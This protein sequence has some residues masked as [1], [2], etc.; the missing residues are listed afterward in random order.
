VHGIDEVRAGAG[1]EEQV[2]VVGACDRE[3][4]A[5]PDRLHQFF[6]RLAGAQADNEFT[7]TQRLPVSGRLY[8]PGRG[9]F[10]D[11]AVSHFVA[12]GTA[13]EQHG[14]D[15]TGGLQG[16]RRPAGAALHR[17]RRPM[18]GSS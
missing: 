8:G 10:S 14:G 4:T 5:R 15:K 13:G 3:Q 17:V 6:L 12:C 2:D 7:D 16:S 1:L 11:L 9:Q 18:P